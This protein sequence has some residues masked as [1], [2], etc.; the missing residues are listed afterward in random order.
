[1]NERYYFHLQPATTAAKPTHKTHR[2][3]LLRNAGGRGVRRSAQKTR[4][5]F[6][7]KFS[8]TA[9]RSSKLADRPA[10]SPDRQYAQPATIRWALLAA[11]QRRTFMRALLRGQDFLR[12]PAVVEFL[13]RRRGEFDRAAH[14]VAAADAGGA[15]AGGAAIRQ[16]LTQDAVVQ[17]SV[18][19]WWSPAYA[20]AGVRRHGAARGPPSAVGGRRGPMRRLRLPRPRC[21]SCWG[22]TAVGRH[23][24]QHCGG[25]EAEPRTVRPKK[26]NAGR[27]GA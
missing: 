6:S 3:R 21:R 25:G 1:M 15:R 11:G 13:V 17:P 18:E 19:A 23:R 24:P 12:D 20:A 26:T 9:L 4:N 8:M 10:R 22:G 16:V 7:L 2:R 27:V 5:K 14:V